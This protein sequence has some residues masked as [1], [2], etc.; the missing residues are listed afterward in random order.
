MLRNLATGLMAVLSLGASLVATAQESVCARVKI[1]IKQE[2]T[3][4]R[5]AFDAE[6]KINNTTDTSVIENVGVTVKVTDENGNPVA[7]TDNPNDTSA[8]FFIRI[9]S[10]ENISDVEGTGSVNPKTTATINWLIIPAPGAGGLSSVGKKY[11]V[12]ATLRYRFANEDSTL[13]VS[14]DVITVKPLPLLTLDYFLTRD[15][16]ADDPMTPA[17][18]PI[19][20]FTLGVR[21]K[22]NGAATAK[23]L[24]IDSAQPKIIEN[25][26]GLLINFQ[27]T[28]SYV[29]D[30]PVQN[31]LLIDFGDIAPS[32]AKMGR[33]VM[34]TTLAG[35]FTEFTANF[36]HSDELGGALTSI[37]QATNPHL[38][39]HDVRVDLPGRDFVKDFLAYDGDVIRIYESDST[40]TEVTNRSSQA[41]LTTQT[42][43]G[44]AAVYRFAFPPTAG[45][46]YARLPD[47]FQGQK[48]LGR[49]SRSD[50]KVIAPENVWL[51]KTRNLEQHRWEYW[52]NLFDVNSTGVYTTQFED[53]GTA[54]RPPVI[55]FIPDR[56][57]REDQQVSFIVEASS[58]NGR[59]VTLS[60][61][62]LPTGATFSQQPADPMTPNLHTA[63]FDW[64]P[65]DGQAGNYFI[66]FTANDGLLASTRSASIRVESA[67]P[68]PGPGTPTIEAPGLDAHVPQTQPNLIVRTS[69]NTQDPTT[70]VQF[71]V[72]SDEAMTQL[73]DTA[74]VEKGTTPGSDGVTS[75][76]VAADLNDNTRYWWR[77]RAFDGVD[78]YSAWVNG[79]FFVNLFNDA[80]ESFNLTAP[81]PNAEVATPLPVLSW[82]NSSDDDGDGVS[83]T[84]QVYS[85]TALSQLVASASGLA[86][87]EGGTTSWTVNEPLTNHGTYYWRVIA[88]DTLGAETPT[89]ARS[90]IVNTG[91]APPSDPIINAPVDG[92][93][94][95]T[96]TVALS[97]QNS[98]DAD[99][100]L[101]TYV[102]EIDTVPTFDSG[103]KRSSGQIIQG[104]SSTTQWSVDELVE[105]QQYWWRV[106]AQDG[107]AESAWVGASFL[108][109]ATNDVP[110]APT[111]RN[112]GD[113]AWSTTTQPTLEAN[114]VEDP[115]GG[116]VSYEFE[117]YQGAQSGNI[118]VSGAS[119]T[120][121]WAVPQALAD[122]TTHRWRVR[123]VDEAGAASGWS[124]FAVLYV[125]TGPYEDPSIQ[126]ITPSTPKAPDVDGARRTV[127]ITW[128]GTDN[129]IEANVALYYSTSRAE[130]AGDLIVDGLRQPA[131]THP[132]SYVWD[133]TSLAPGAYYVYG[134]I[135]DSRGVGRA[136]APGAVVIPNP[137]QSGAITVTAAAPF[138]TTEAGG[139]YNF[140][141]R[142]A[143]APTEAVT[144]QVRSSR[145]SEGMPSPAT[146]T[147]TP[148]NWGTDQPVTV[149]GVRDCAP[150]GVQ[151]YDIQVGSSVSVDPNYIGV[152]AA[153]LQMRNIGLDQS[154]T[155]NVPTLHICR[156]AVVTK[157]RVGLLRWEYTLTA[158]LTNT[159]TPLTSVTAQLA[160]VPGVVQ[161]VEGQ[162]QFGAV[163]ASETVKST[164]TI[165]IRSSLPFEQLVPVLGL[166]FRWTVTTTE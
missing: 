111:V 74:T 151:S 69:S 63:V 86:G 150:D 81:A 125:S 8:K 37:L 33:W 26:Q 23:M 12:G 85:D 164:D 72:Y 113:G 55:Q 32:T 51:S 73:V 35:T 148:Q 19:E 107:R 66:V 46:A 82:T 127:T 144:V 157:A 104:G 76:L 11:L 160:T 45:F 36:T 1:E 118:A 109:N 123:A 5:Q 108:M 101:I 145:P 39:I 41:S 120:T 24:K 60:A 42:G 9:S 90:F 61:A 91:N 6:M 99:N 119:P 159:G 28:G 140:N 17:I 7:V 158:E 44:G 138:V 13:E 89:I 147:F 75:Y 161:I 129:N 88:I 67:E 163:G 21:V 59:P 92:S 87:A 43:E 77:A 22:N 83:Y 136:F 102:F 154:D 20:P 18:E 153:P 84:V 128:Q 25:N 103:G 100:D 57:V 146:L 15:V 14:P 142:L 117:V 96:T 68:P 93:S 156:I 98:A 54:P 80:P 124:A 4:E 27:L 139:A 2:L 38:L 132:G 143:T 121:A 71:E 94:V 31:S 165:T 137:S 30:T 49:I 64:T 16:N 65:E 78:R 122:D 166:G 105:N 110:P 155:T 114:P 53:L 135:Y 52:V 162:L 40:D 58:P 95:T 141:V 134:V 50:A 152:S 106:K 131:G 62:P 149:T 115:E 112:P 10:R 79:R 48:V 97:I 34:E 3:L 70:Q 130:F 56:T 29:N 47:P 116:P 133:V 126:V